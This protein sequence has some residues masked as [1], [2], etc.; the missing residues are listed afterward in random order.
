MALS[1][2]LAAVKTSRTFWARAAIVTASIRSE[3]CIAA[4]GHAPLL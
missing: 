4:L 2:E 1:G 3:R